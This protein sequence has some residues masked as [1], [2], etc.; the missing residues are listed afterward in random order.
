MSAHGPSVA[1][2]PT[3][4]RTFGGPAWAA[5]GTLPLHRVCYWGRRPATGGAAMRRWSQGSQL[6]SP[7]R[8][9]LARSI[10]QCVL[11]T[12][13]AP[14]RAGGQRDLR[15]QTTTLSSP[16]RTMLRLMFHNASRAYP[17][18]ATA[19]ST[20]ANPATLIAD[21]IR[22]R[23]TRSTAVSFDGVASPHSRPP[24]FTRTSTHA[25]LP[26]CCRWSASFNSRMLPQPQS[27]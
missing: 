14:N 23:R 26:L 13:G 5:G 4:E 9:L 8:A 16:G 3:D 15:G 17:A 24:G 2:R 6:T 7:A 25:A 1:H 10:I 12:I 11:S 21:M 22:R 20:T 27:V 18:G 19:I